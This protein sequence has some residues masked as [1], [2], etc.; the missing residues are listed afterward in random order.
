MEEED[1][2]WKRERDVKILLGFGIS[3]SL[4][5]PCTKHLFQEKGGALRKFSKSSETS[6]MTDCLAQR[7]HL[8]LILIFESKSTVE[9]QKKLSIALITLKSLK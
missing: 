1:D 2:E 7:A 6:L 3:H 8:N 9:I 5:W 4:A